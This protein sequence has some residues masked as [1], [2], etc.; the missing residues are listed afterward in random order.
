M[1]AIDGVGEA[2]YGEDDGWGAVWS[3]DVARPSAE[4]A[5]GADAKVVGVVEAALSGDRVFVG[6]EDVVNE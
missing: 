6:G 2:I 5:R 4:V 3:D 1:R